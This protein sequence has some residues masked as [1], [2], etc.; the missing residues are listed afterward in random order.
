MVH[1]SSSTILT[2][3]YAIIV[4]SGHRVIGGSTFRKLWKE[5]CPYIV[6][7]RP[8]TDL[9]WRCQRNNTHIFR[10]ANLTLDEKTELVQKHQKHLDLVNEERELYKKMTA[11]AKETVQ[12]KG[13]QRLQRTPA[14]TGDF[15]L[16][17][18][19]D[20]AQQVHIPSMSA[21]PGPIYF[22]TPRK[23]GIFGICCEGFPQQVN[24]LIDE[25]V[26]SSK[27]S[28]A[29][30]SYLHHFFENYGQGEKVLHLH[31]DNCSG[32]NKNRY[33]LW[34]FAWRIEKGLHTE[35]TL[36]FMPPGHTKFA[37]DWC[38]GLL[39][40]CFRRT[41]D[42]S[43]LEDFTKVVSESTP[44]SKVNIPQLV[45]REDGTVVVPTYNW[46]EFF[47]P[48]YRPLHGIK[49][50]GHFRFSA[51]HPGMVYYRATIADAEEVKQLSIR[52]QFK[53]LAPMPTV[54]PPPLL[55]RERQQYL[56]NNIREYVRE[57]V[58]DIVCPI[59]R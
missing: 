17:Y 57:D 20:F 36:N 35:I 37:P 42:V 59:P 31:C 52:Q 56:Y 29:V 11:E 3:N 2:I 39:K 55:S 53:R 28:N 49:A 32:Q 14:N 9:C 7:A 18:S 21:Q 19:F 51:D 45:G 4:I 16:H 54:I 43:C 41:D 38:F 15:S 10:S 6:V 47:I 34:Y 13:L 12:Q 26:N 40:R 58:R 33:V 50:I 8:M 48:A 1:F 24:Y 27:G 25:A 22:L 46:Q 23:C 5:L 30:I 44:V